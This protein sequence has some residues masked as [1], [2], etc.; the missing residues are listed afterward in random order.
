M[1]ES[2]PRPARRAVDERAVAAR[3]AVTA[4]FFIN[5][6]LFATW[7]SR[8]PAVEAARGLSH[9]GL[10]AALLLTAAGAV[11]AMPLAGGWSGRAGT[12]AVCRIA[13]TLYCLALPLLAVAPGRVAWGAALLLFGAAHGALDVAMN[14]QA[15]GVEKRYHRPVMSSFHALFSVGGL[16][17]AAAG[18]LLAASGLPIGPHFSLA[19]AVLGAGALVAFRYLLPPERPWPSSS[20]FSSKEKPPAFRLP[21]RALAAPGLCAMCIMMGE[22]AM[23]DWSAVYLRGTLG[24]AE[25]TAA[26]GYAAFS[27]AMAGGRFAG[28]A[29]AAKYGAV[30][31]ARGG[32]LLAAAGMIT[33]LLATHAS[34]ALAGFAAAGA[35][36]AT[37]VPLVFS[38]AARIP[39][40]SAGAAM[41]SVTTLGYSGFLLGPPVI[42]FLAQSF[43]L[44]AA[45]WLIVAASA[46]AALLAGSLRTRRGGAAAH[47]FDNQG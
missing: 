11:I 27:I 1:R 7:V 45:L 17:G 2:R 38:A 41:A 28:D 40:V 4:L 19:A 33:S 3:R 24:A 20:S 16:A 31:L 13:A 14:A 36:F 26:A 22:G 42:G 15:A 46:G 12:G 47:S 9:A 6:A 37:V 8:L 5:G 34:L 29:L 25:G 30:A 10:G 21:T 32:A 18:G 44:R 23:A 35:G 43:G 39:G